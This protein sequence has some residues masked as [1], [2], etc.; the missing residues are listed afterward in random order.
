MKNLIVEKEIELLLFLENNLK[1]ISKKKLKS[2]LKYKC[3]KVNNKVVTKFDHKLKVNDKVT[4]NLNSTKQDNLDIL[5][6]DKYLLVVYKKEGLLTVATTKEKENTLYHI[7][8]EYLNRK[9]EKAFIV[10]RLDKDTSG[11][12]VFAKSEKVKN[13]L[14]NNWDKYAVKRMYAAIIVGKL[15]KSGTIESY[16]K[17]NDNHIV[18]VSK[19]K[20][21]SKKCITKYKVIKSKENFSLIEIEIKTGR[22]H[23]IRVQFNEINHPILG[24]TKYG[25][26]KA[27]RMYLDAN[28]MEFIHPIN[29]KKIIFEESFN[30]FTEVYN[31]L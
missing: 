16:L 12:V 10:H 19:D 22:K 28:K 18:Y 31:K 21:N 25:K 23:Q 24:D 2:L 14:Q 30:N 9:K 20:K 17:E 7:V 5:Y 13:I 29:N 3:I 8:R 6:E 1:D 15:K 27:K 11:I 26:V 4:V